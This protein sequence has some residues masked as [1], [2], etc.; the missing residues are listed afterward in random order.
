MRVHM[1]GVGTQGVIIVHSVVGSVH[2][3]LQETITMESV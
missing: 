2:V 3:C 1:G